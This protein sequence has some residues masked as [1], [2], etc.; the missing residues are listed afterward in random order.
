VAKVTLIIELGDTVRH[1][2]NSMAVLTKLK[3]LMAIL[4]EHSTIV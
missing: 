3:C 1:K 4:A 2:V